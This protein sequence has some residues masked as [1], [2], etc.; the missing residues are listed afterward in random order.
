MKHL[1]NGKCLFI[2]WSKRVYSSFSRDRI[3]RVSV[4]RDFVKRIPTINTMLSGFEDDPAKLEDFINAVS[5]YMC[6]Y[7]QFF[8]CILVTLGHQLRSA[9]SL[10]RAEDTCKLKD[11]CP[12]F[13]LEDP[14]RPGATLD[15][16]IIKGQSKS[17]RGWNHK[18]TARGLCPMADINIFDEDP[19]CV[20]RHIFLFH[21][22]LVLGHI[23]TWY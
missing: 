10:A 21:L 19:Q 17:L 14:S 9:A 7:A 13:L 2:F 6:L 18:D 23:L 20:I 4:F 3:Y 15:P 5:G 22:C 11:L 1:I 8:C 12:S 16:P